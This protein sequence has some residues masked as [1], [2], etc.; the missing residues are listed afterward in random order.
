MLSFMELVRGAV[1]LQERKSKERWEVAT[2]LVANWTN[3]AK[4]S[5]ENDLLNIVSRP[6]FGTLARPFNCSVATCVWLLLL[7][8]QIAAAQRL[9]P[10]PVEDVMAA[11][12]FSEYQQIQFSPDG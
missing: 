4:V 9:A 11:R 7:Q 12:T 3:G 1:R 6:R 2:E 5:K 8:V 10:L